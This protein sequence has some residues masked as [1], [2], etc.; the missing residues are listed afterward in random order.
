M[1]F[2]SA[3]EI[4]KASVDDE[5]FLAFWPV[6][7]EMTVIRSGVFVERTDGG[8]TI[9]I[10]K[11]IVEGVEGAFDELIAREGDKTIY[12]FR[13]EAEG[14]TIKL[15]V[16]EQDGHKALACLQYELLALVVE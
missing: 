8:Y 14:E 16:D 5:T 9:T 12:T 2:K 10:P 3:P 13:F 1:G 4:R 11:T 15:F 6:P 7:Q